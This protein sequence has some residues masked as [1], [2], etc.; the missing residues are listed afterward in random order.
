MYINTKP[1]QRVRVSVH[2]VGIL[3]LSKVT[4]SSSSA[5]RLSVTDCILSVKAIFQSAMQPFVHPAS[6]SKPLSLDDAIQ[7]KEWYPPGVTSIIT[8]TFDGYIGRMEDGTILKYLH[9]FPAETDPERVRV[10]ANMERQA[11]AS[12]DV[13]AQIYQILGDHDRIIKFLGSDEW[14]LCLEFA[15]NGSLAEYLKD[16]NNSPT[17]A[18]RLGWARQ[19]AE[20]V[21]YI[22]TKG[23]LH[24]DI[25]V[26]NILLDKNLEV[27]LV[28][29]QGRYISPDGTK[30]LDGFSSESSQSAMPRD[31]YN[32]ADRKTDIFALGSALYFI[33]TGH[34]PFPDLTSKDEETKVERQFRAGLLPP[35]EPQLGGEIIHKCWRGSY[36]SA[37]EVVEDLGHLDATVKIEQGG[38]GGAR[39]GFGSPESH[40]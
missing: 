6:D 38:D 1:D 27:K 12:L 9:K 10:T 34:E 25:H 30:V 23:V 26:R 21:A 29:F 37:L 32:Q 13:E 5:S 7:I 16:H 8:S 20:G 14:G 36:E 35:L 31:D 2:K 24:C 3:S 15:D 39:R 22:H 33:M 4:P 11:K 19:T 18:Q 28:D 17:R 40:A